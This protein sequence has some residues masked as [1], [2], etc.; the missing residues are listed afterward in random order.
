MQDA[1]RGAVDLVVV[2]D[3]PVALAQPLVVLA[4]SPR[5]A[6]QRA[7]DREHVHQ[8]QQLVADVEVLLGQALERH[9]PRGG[10]AVG[11]LG[12]A[13][14]EGVGL[15]ACAAQLARQGVAD[16]R[17]ARVVVAPDPDLAQ[18]LTRADRVGLFAVEAVG[19]TQPGHVQAQAQVGAHAQQ[20]EHPPLGVGLFDL[21][22][23][24]QHG[25]PEVEEVELVGERTLALL[26]GLFAHLTQRTRD[27]ADQVEGDMPQELLHGHLEGA[28]GEGEDPRLGGQGRLG[29]EGVEHGGGGHER[30]GVVRAAKKVR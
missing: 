19:L 27:R 13:A 9:A 26:R 23:Q 12:R 25:L 24:R 16:A 17:R 5:R 8:R 30:S 18:R 2:R 10:R 21:G 11:R 14:T 22:R 1:R 29:L 7:F 15:D 4:H 20:L 6:P 3:D 28:G